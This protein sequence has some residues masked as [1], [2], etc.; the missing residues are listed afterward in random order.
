MTMKN[1]VLTTTKSSLQNHP[2]FYSL[3]ICI[4]YSSSDKSVHFENG[5]IESRLLDFTSKIL[6]F[7]LFLSTDC[8]R[9][10]LRK[11][12][13]YRL[14]IVFCCYLLLDLPNQ[15][16]EGGISEESTALLFPQEINTATG[17]GYW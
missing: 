1:R 11:L 12:V 8:N 14:Q 15:K 16:K 5:A 7:S 3:V 13:I 9:W 17:Q 6:P 4:V 10:Q 2:F